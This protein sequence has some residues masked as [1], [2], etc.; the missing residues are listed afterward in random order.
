MS[1]SLR[2]NSFRG[3]IFFFPTTDCHVGFLEKNPTFG[4]DS[5]PIFEEIL[6][7]AVI[8][9]VRFFSFMPYI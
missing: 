1:S 5:F 3:F 4:Q 7:Q 6:K 8:Y 9:E 2:D